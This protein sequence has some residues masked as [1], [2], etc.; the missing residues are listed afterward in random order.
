MQKFRTPNNPFDNIDDYIKG[1]PL[2]SSTLLYDL[3]RTNAANN[4]VI[5]FKVELPEQP[6][7]DLYIALVS[8]WEEIHQH[9]NRPVRA[10]A[11]VYN[12][13]S[14]KYIER[15]LTDHADIFVT[16]IP[17]YLRRIGNA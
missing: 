9:F 8:R 2:D 7:P 3:T 1:L 13:M 16:I 5:E 12:P 14:E 4:N 17:G 11:Y 15:L 10:Y 6:N